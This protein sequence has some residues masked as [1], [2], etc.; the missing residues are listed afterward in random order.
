MSTIPNPDVEML[1]E[2][3]E[4]RFLSILLKDK[5]CLQDAIAFGIIS[6]ENGKPGH[7]FNDK[8]NLLYAIIRNN[9][10][11]YGTLLT[12]S[13]MDSIVGMMQI[14]TEEEKAS[15]VIYWDKIWNMHDATTEDYALL[16]E[17]IN[18]R[19]VLWQFYNVWKDG[20]KIVKAINGHGGMIKDFVNSLNSLKNMEPDPYSRSMSINEGLEEAIKYIDDRR[21][22]P[23][24]DQSIKC[25]IEAID[26]I[27]HGFIR[28]SYTVVSGMIGGGKTTLMMNIAFNMAKM[29]YNVVYVSLE[30]DAKLF[31][32]R[33]LA[34]HAL[35][36]YSRIKTGGTDLN[37][38]LS[39]Y[40][41]NKLREAAI[42]LRDNIK[43]QYH[44]LQF[45]QGTKLTKIL[46]DVDR[47]RSMHKKIDVLIV[48]YLQVIGVE[49]NTVGRY[50]VDLANVHKRLMG[51][52]RKHNIVTFTALQLKSASSKEIRK[53]AEK[54]TTEADMGAVSV[55]AED[56]SGSQMIIADADN[57]LGIVLNGD[58][59]VTKMFISIS[60]A[61]DDESRK[62][63]CLDFDPKIGLVKDAEYSESQIKA[64]DNILFDHQI[65][66]DSLE[67]EDTLFE[68]A[69]KQELQKKD[70]VP[71]ES[72]ISKTDKVNDQPVSEIIENIES[73]LVNQKSDSAE[74][75]EFTDELFAPN[76][77]LESKNE[78]PK[79]KKGQ[80]M[81]ERPVDF[82]SDV[83]PKGDSKNYLDE[84][85]NDV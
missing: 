39:D 69:E 66:E 71:E 30:K 14:G 28:G 53:K 35:T 54:V 1:A 22:N 23:H 2:K 58:K 10:L 59:P 84:L 38:G 36:D 67:S 33:T 40:W 29:G 46:S 44:C 18:D 68:E 19:Y 7:F 79:I 8:N 12:R 24:D 70:S 41:Y 51:Y 48:D 13:A 81:V 21:S 57:A 47:L 73:D 56:Y 50:D 64:V 82:P 9:F 15:M 49:T 5:E 83:S 25:G 27:F 31:F 45:V 32:R 34:C 16:K 61:R 37:Y 85:F 42:D 6:K 74:N 4:A 55:N 11:K 76:A 77:S 20:D 78:K 75:N 3:E 26:R 65:T 60:K 72:K 63:I 43:P 52:G 62:T 80:D 17:H